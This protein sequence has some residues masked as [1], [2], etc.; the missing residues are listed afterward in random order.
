MGR[1]EQ[2][3]KRPCQSGDLG[4]AD[5]QEEEEKQ[6]GKK[7]QERREEKRRARGK[8]DE[9]REGKLCLTGSFK[10]CTWHVADGRKAPGD[11]VTALE[12]EAGCCSGN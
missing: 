3:S 2:K 7:R 9:R 11:D 1:G 8:R 10:G 12:T 6:E 4:E 5:R